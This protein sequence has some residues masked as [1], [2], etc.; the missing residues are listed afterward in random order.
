M[1][2]QRTLTL[3][4]ARSGKIGALSAV[5]GLDGFVDTIVTPVGLRSGPGEN[6][7]PI[8]TLK[9]F[10]QRI[11]AAGGMS[12]NIELYPR[13]DKLGGNGPIMAN[14]LLAAGAR[15]TYIG[16]VGTPVVH[17]VFADMASR[18]RT[19]SICAAAQTTAV[20]CNDGKLML[21][22]MRCLDEITYDRICGVM[23]E[24]AFHAEIESADLV[25]LVNWTMIPNMTS[26]FTALTQKVLPK[27]GS[28]LGKIFFS[29]WPIQRS[30]RPATFARRWRQFETSAA[31]DASH[32][33]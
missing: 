9:E 30:V 7:T 2:R 10:G 20:E 26:I 8:S 6:F 11:V 28:K 3:L 14:A 15:V 32:L 5:V 33:G 16:A 12:T 21:G 25:A 4:S 17:P 29:I 23:G 27:L 31:L 19:V 18:A 1:F 13:L 22:Q 24:A